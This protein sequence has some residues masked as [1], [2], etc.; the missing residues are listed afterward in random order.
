M[1]RDRMVMQLDGTATS[2]KRRDKSKRIKC[3]DC[4]ETVKLRKELVV[5]DG[6][7]YHLLC[8]GFIHAPKTA[9]CSDC[10]VVAPCLCVGT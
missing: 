3:A 5:Q 10:F 9:P 4:G 1:G 2:I 7:N 6:R 8:A